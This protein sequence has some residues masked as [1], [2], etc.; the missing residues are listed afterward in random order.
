MKFKSFQTFR[1]YS[2]CGF[3]PIFY[4]ITILKSNFQC[5]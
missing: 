2:H 1:K 3:L 5:L 4:T